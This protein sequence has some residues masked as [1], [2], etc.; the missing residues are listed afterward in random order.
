MSSDDEYEGGPDGLAEKLAGI[1]DAL[2]DQRAAT[3]KFVTSCSRPPLLGFAHL[4]PAFCVYRATAEEGRLP[5][6]AT[7][8]NLLKLPPYDSEEMLRGKLEYAI[9]AGAGFELS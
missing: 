8:M 5:T 6:S 2:A 7:C 9:S 3:L 4:Q 1:D